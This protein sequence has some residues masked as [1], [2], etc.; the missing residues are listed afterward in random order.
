MM[1]DEELS[2]LSDAELCELMDRITDEVFLRFMQHA[3]EERK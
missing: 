1:S 3:D 2:R